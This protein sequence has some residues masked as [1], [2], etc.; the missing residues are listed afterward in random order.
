M[1][2]LFPIFIFFAFG[3]FAAFRF[4]AA[5][6]VLAYALPLYVVRFSIGPLPTTL[7]ELM[8][9]SLA[10]VWMLRGGPRNLLDYWEVMRGKPVAVAF[11]GALF[12]FAIAGAIGVAVAPNAWTAL[13]LLRAYWLEPMLLF[14]IILTAVRSREQLNSLFG[15]LALS[16]ISIAG[17]AIIQKFTGWG[18]P[19]PWFDERRVVGIYPY[20]NAVG[21]YLAPI[22]PLALL[23]F[24]ERAHHC[25]SLFARAAWVITA[26]LSFCSMI[27]AVVFAKTEAAY[28]A[29]AATG[30]LFGAIYSRASRFLAAGSAA[31]AIMALFTYPHLA[32]VVQ[33]KLLLQDWSGHVR[34]VVW[35]ESV[36]MLKDNWFFG[37]GLAGYK[38]A[39]EPYHTADYIEIFLYPH[40]IVLNF[41]SELGLLGVIAFALVVVLFCALCFN[42][43]RRPD[44]FSRIAGLSLF[45][46]MF[47]ILVHGLVDVPYFKN[48]LAAFFWLLLAFAFVVYTRGE[49]RDKTQA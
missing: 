22:I 2:H 33:E 20:P 31:V 46:S 34:K 32:D 16:G 30:F 36:A 47:I 39:F 40:S 21:L 38:T 35:A 19:H 18:I 45:S 14:A 11:I 1:E 44:Y 17:V 9:L 37:A 8:I 43:F 12:S 48:D 13:G 5:L 6:A 7:L 49:T 15:A 28:V 25:A 27:A 42:I 3:L 26:A 41:W 4:H 10:A 29:L 24:R 23:W